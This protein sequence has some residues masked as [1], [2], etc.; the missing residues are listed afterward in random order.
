MRPSF[1]RSKSNALRQRFLPTISR[2]DSMAPSINIFS[3]RQY[4]RSGAIFLATSAGD[5][6]E[7]EL[8]ME[9]LYTEWT[10][11]HDKLLWENRDASAA[12]QAVLL[13]RG[14][15]G[16]QE[17]LKKLR[18]VNSSAYERLFVKE[19]HS[20]GASDFD[21]MPEKTKLVPVSE[22]LRRIQWDY[23][24]SSS[25]FSILHY[26]RVEDMVVESPMDAPNKSIKGSSTQL[27]DALPEHR[28]V[29]VKYK[30]Q[31]CWDREKRLDKFFSNG[32]IEK[33]MEDYDEWKRKKDA[34]W[35]WLRQRQE[36]VTDTVR[37]VLGDDR[38]GIFKDMS[39]ELQS[40]LEDPATSAK[41]EAE[42]Y[43]KASLE[44]F[45]LAQDDQS[46]SPNSSLD[47]YLIPQ[48]D[49]ES[50]E[51][52]SELVA[53]SPDAVL[54]QSVLA[55]LS[56]AL[57][58]LDGKQLSTTSALGSDAAVANRE[59]PELLDDD[60]T[61]TFV[62]GS[63]AGGQKINKTNSKVSLLHIPTRIRVECQ[64]TRS[65][66]QNRKIAR[67]RL[68]L[69]LDEFF[70]GSQSRAGIKAEKASSKKAKAKARSRA[71]TRKKAEEK[72]QA[73]SQ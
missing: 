2:I 28:I 7:A 27:V 4:G 43:V 49:M 57:G 69:K 26:D 48:N 42:A 67:K 33:I 30:E 65:L 61:E 3:A 22:I 34:N 60:I 39:K 6:E 23:S 14:L 73:K 9:N 54:R 62:R 59:L 25:D 17:R 18:D 68:R 37:L 12:E 55:E 10:L 35:E 53:L 19:N 13:G 16:V 40:T 44:L 58:R 41:K 70:H 64:D 1:R 15:R 11:E 32:G 46:Q 21:S 63:G 66:Q 50:A 47:S 56:L 20:N 51:C 31:V 71:R 36:Q 8:A 52:L 45:R 29:A 24:L 5:D 72:K 38:Y